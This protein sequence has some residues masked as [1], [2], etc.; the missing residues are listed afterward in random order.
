[1]C[2]RRRRPRAYAGIGAGLV[3][4]DRRLAALFVLV[5]VL[6]HPLLVR[7]P[8]ELGRLHAFGEE[9]LDR[10]CI[11]KDVHRFR[12]T[13][14][15]GVAFGDV[16]ALD[17]GALGEPCPVFL[18]FW[19]LE[20]DAEVTGDVDQR[21]L[22]E[23]GH[24]ARIGAAA[25]HRGVAAVLARP[26]GGERRLAQRVI[27]A[28]LRSELAVEIKAGPG[29]VDGVD[30]ERA[31]LVAQLHDRHRGSVDREIDAEA[32]AAAGGEQRREQR[33]I[34]LLGH[35]VMDEADA[36]LV[37][38]LAV[39]VLRVDDHEAALVVAEMAF[40]QRQR[41]FADRAEADHHDGP[42]DTG[43]NGPISHD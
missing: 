16:D 32:L 5:A 1:M 37:E 25:G 26:L 39:L 15:L 35:R 13:G 40:D 14:A 42:V 7:A 28:R 8:A 30:V 4:I 17:A 12:P 23:P 33:A 31:E 19:L 18:G 21:L 27:G 20:L 10:P 24:H 38:Q 34:I 6:R 29:L 22:D 41:A 36:A 11:D 9:T 43:V 2:V 3:E